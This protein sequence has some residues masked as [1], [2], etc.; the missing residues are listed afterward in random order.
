MCF[1]DDD[2]IKAE[3]NIFHRLPAVVPGCQ[4]KH[5]DV[6]SLCIQAC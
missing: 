6:I 2:C 4:M 1:D 3:K 5:I